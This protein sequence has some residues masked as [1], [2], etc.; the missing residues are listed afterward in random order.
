MLGKKE[1]VI[2]LLVNL[3]HHALDMYV[4]FFVF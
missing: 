1:A 3:I 2:V 4:D